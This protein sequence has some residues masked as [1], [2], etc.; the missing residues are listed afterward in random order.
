MSA[1]KK[2]AKVKMKTDRGVA[3]RFKITG[4]GLVKC[5]HQNLRHILTKKTRKRKR[6]L[7]KMTYVCTS[8]LRAIMRQLPYA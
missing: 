1:K 4:S 6:A 7:R 3:K 5:R 2:P 8:N